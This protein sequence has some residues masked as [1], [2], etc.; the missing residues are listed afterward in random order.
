ME[1]ERGLRVLTGRARAVTITLVLFGA[2]NVI[3]AAGVLAALA[4]GEGFGDAD[5]YISGVLGLGIL[6]I[7]ATAI[8]SV[9]AVSLWI[10]RAHAN[11]RATRDESFEHSP[12]WAILWFFVPIA[13]LFK[14][15]QAMRQLWN[16]SHLQS[17]G[18]TASGPF[19]VKIWWGF[20]IAGNFATRLFFPLGLL[21]FVVDAYFL[22]RLVSAVTQAQTHEMNASYAFA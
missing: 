20:W 5:G 9:V 13:N 1:L 21:L 4:A 18:Y 12:T 10:Y 19:E 6:A 8:A 16:D 15:Y 22:Y 7:V 3:C 14:P 2:A 11:L 17:D